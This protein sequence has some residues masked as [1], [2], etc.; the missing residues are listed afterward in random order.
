MECRLCLSALEAKQT[1]AYFPN[2]LFE[3]EAEKCFDIYVGIRSMVA[4]GYKEISSILADQ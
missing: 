3:R 2:G 4:G 1:P